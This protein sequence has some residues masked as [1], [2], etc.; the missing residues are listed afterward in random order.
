MAITETTD[1]VTPEQPKTKPHQTQE[2]PLGSGSPRILETLVNNYSSN[3][4]L[5]ADADEYLKKLRNVLEDH[6]QPVRVQAKRLLSF[7]G[8]IAFT[9]GEFGIVLIFEDEHP[10]TPYE[11]MQSTLVK[12]AQESFVKD[13]SSHK[14]INVISVDRYS[15]NRYLQMA[16]YILKCFKVHE[17]PNIK[18][19]T[20]D[21]FDKNVYAIDIE[22]NLA[23][24]KSFINT[25]SPREIHPRMDFGFVCNISTGFRNGGPENNYNSNYVN[26]SKWFAVSAFVE[27]VPDSADISM[28]GFSQNLPK[29]TPLIRITDIVSLIPSEVIIPLVLSLSAEIF[30]AYNI[31]QQPHRIIKKGMPNIG[32]LLMDPKTGKPSS[33]GEKDVNGFFNTFFNPPALAID[34]SSNFNFIP[35][36]SQIIRPGG[37]NDTFSN[38]L[39]TNIYGGQPIGSLFFSEIAGNAD[40]KGLT[41]DDV[42]DSRQLDYL[43]LCNLIGYNEKVAKLLYRYEDPMERANIIQELVTDFRKTSMCYVAVLNSDF[44]TKLSSIIAPYINMSSNVSRTIPTINS[45]LLKNNSYQNTPTL[46]GFNKNQFNYNPF[47][48]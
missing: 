9:C 13:Y 41:S 3:G 11:I 8:A 37:L 29:F 24:V 46:S 25:Y 48:I 21:K 2:K 45:N 15:Y 1:N 17:D 23:E 35:G 36:L 33:I 34:L 6:S 20:I 31:W 27:F 19:L 30:C 22:T 16:E 44:I 18:Q 38:F 26:R 32:G 43:N 14:L 7:Q 47:I 5:S 40:I 28:S 12:K 4:P 39:K 10:Q 42:I